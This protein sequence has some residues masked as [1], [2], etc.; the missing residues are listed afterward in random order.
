MGAFFGVGYGLEQALWFAPKGK[1]PLEKITFRRSNAFPIVGDECR[2][3]RNG[4][5]VIE[6]TGYAKYEVTGSGAETWLSHAPR[7]PHAGQVASSP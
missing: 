4:V 6:I 2:A 1:K 3:V 5:G 7:Q